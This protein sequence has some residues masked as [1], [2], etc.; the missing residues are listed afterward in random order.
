MARRDPQV[1]QLTP[2]ELEDIMA[3]AAAAG[4]DGA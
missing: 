3:M 2:E 1:V 4:G